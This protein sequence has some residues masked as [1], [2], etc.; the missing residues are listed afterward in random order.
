VLQAGHGERL[1]GLLSHDNEITR[2]EKEKYE[3]SGT[4]VLCKFRPMVKAEY[5]LKLLVYKGFDEEK[6]EVHFHLGH[7]S[8]YN[9]LEYTVDL[10]RYLAAEYQF[11][12]IPKLYY[13]DN[14]C[15]DH[16]RCIWGMCRIGVPK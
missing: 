6:R 15:T 11:S 3:N 14:D 12:T 8:Y 16:K 4:E 1:S 7:Q 9:T 10:S 13:H 5:T 2:E